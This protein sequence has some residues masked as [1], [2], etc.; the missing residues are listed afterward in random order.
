MTDK[1][2]LELVVEE[3]RPLVSQHLDKRMTGT[4][5]SLSYE[6]KGC[7]KAGEIIHLESYG[8][9]TQFQGKPAVLETIIDITDRK[10]VEME[11]LK[12]RK[13]ESVG[14]LAGGI[15]HD[16]NNLLTIIIGNIS[17]TKMNLE[18][19]NVDQKNFNL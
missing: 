11:L 7:T 17:M 6:F 12:V 8:S 3:D 1:N 4:D 18:R 2:P 14:I 15:A 9:L 13:L 19:E 16:F 5:N 10:K